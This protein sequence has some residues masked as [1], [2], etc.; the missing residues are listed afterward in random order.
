[1]KETSATITT[2]ASSPSHLILYIFYSISASSQDIVK[3]KRSDGFV[4]VMREGTQ[5]LRIE[6][7]RLYLNFLI[8]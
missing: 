2:T 8:V 1:M 7:I 5:C 4:A 6:N 3:E